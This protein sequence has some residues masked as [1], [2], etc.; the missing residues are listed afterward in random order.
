[1]TKILISLSSLF[2]H[3]AAAIT[4]WQLLTIDVEMLLT[5]GV[6]MSTNDKNLKFSQGC[7]THIRNIWGIIFLYICGHCNTPGLVPSSAASLTPVLKCLLDISALL[8]NCPN[9]QHWWRCVPWT[10]Q[11]QC[12]KKRK[13]EA[14]L[15]SAFIE[16]PYTQ[17][18]Q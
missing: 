3:K 16:V 5:I 10:L 12:S 8:P 13:K 2:C 15:Y 18:A 17:G 4:N 1:M 6:V 7:I 11:H 14:D 9:F